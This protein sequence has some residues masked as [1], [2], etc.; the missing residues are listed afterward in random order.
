MSRI[1]S[2][3]RSWDIVGTGT[4]ANARATAK[5]ASIITTVGLHEREVTGQRQGRPRLET[6]SKLSLAA[7]GE[8]ALRR[9]AQRRSS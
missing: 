6:V 2:S 3:R 4:T 5:S 7:D 1:G 9:V 8:D